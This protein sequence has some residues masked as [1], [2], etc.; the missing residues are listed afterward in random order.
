MHVPVL[1]IIG[2][3]VLAGLLATG[4]AF[5]AGMGQALVDAAYSDDLRMVEALLQRGANPDAVL[6][7]GVT[8][9]TPFQMRQ[10]DSE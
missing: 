6:V 9:S 3:A 2:G 1:R 7:R 4:G 5:A 10:S 8:A